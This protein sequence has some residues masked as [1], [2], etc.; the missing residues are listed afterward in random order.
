LTNVSGSSVTDT[1][2][3]QSAGY[4]IFFVGVS[5]FYNFDLG[6]KPTTVGR[7]SGALGVF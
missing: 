5:L 6:K 2:Q 4:Q 1:S 7:S 3:F